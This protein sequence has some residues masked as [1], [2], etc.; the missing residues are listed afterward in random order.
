VCIGPVL[1]IIFGAIAL[2]QIRSSGGRQGGEGMAKAGIILGI[3][4]VV[5]IVA[6]IVWAAIYTS[7]NSST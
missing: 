5:L 4:F 2:T 3:V 7:S 1:A 6:Y